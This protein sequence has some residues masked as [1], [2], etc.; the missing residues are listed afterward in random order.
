MEY[1]TK[2]LLEVTKQDLMIA[3]QLILEY[4]DY[5][6]EGNGDN[7]SAEERYNLL[8]TTRECMIIVE[9]NLKK[10]WE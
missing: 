5:Y 7:L 3:C 10:L 6:N 8:D 1:Q 4:V 2:E 9:N